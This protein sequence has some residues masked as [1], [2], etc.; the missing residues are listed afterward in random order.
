[1]YSIYAAR[2]DVKKSVFRGRIKSLFQSLTSG[3]VNVWAMCKK[4]DMSMVESDIL[5]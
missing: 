3:N 2:V 5:L 1:M 4:K